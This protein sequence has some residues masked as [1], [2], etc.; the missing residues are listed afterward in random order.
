MRW[1]WIFNT[2]E[3]RLSSTR[4]TPKIDVAFFKTAMCNTGTTNPCPFGIFAF[5]MIS[6]SPNSSFHWGNVF[7]MCLQSSVKKWRFFFPARFPC[8][9]EKRA[10]TEDKSLRKQWSFQKYHFNLM[11]VDRNLPLKMYNMNNLSG[12]PM[13]FISWGFNESPST[14]ISLIV[15]SLNVG[16]LVKGWNQKVTS[17]LLPLLPFFFG[18]KRPL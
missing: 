3:N 11:K 8:K 2:E 10:A 5:W 12:F 4:P 7:K 14:K 13:F 16:S 1:K 17:R 9:S 6:M 18:V 15:L